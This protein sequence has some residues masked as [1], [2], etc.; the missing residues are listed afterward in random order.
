[1][2]C[3]QLIA[4]L[5]L[6]CPLFAQTGSI[7]SSMTTN[8][9]GVSKGTMHISPRL[10]PEPLVTG[11]PYSAQRVSEHVQVAPDGTR[12]TSTNQQETIATR[13]GACGRSGP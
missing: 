2:R 13:R 3:L 12:F 5:A 7:T 10:H 9:A 8:A 4:G 6:T 1:M 11:A